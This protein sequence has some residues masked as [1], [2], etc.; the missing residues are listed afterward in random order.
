MDSTTKWFHEEPIATAR[1]FL[2]QLHPDNDR[3]GLGQKCDWIFRGVDDAKHLLLPKAWRDA[4]APTLRKSVSVKSEKFLSAQRMSARC[5]GQGD[6][7]RI[8]TAVRQHVAELRAVEQFAALAD[9]VGR[10]AGTVDAIDANSI[11]SGLLGNG[12]I[13]FQPTA[14]LAVAQHHGVPT[15]LLDWTDSP[16]HAAVFASDTWEESIGKQ[17]CVY[18][19]ASSGPHI[20]SRDVPFEL[21]MLAPQIFRPVRSATQ[22]MVAQ[23]GCFTF[24]RNP[25]GFYVQHG[26]WPTV[27]DS[28]RE[29]LADADTPRKGWK[30]C[31]LVKLTLPG[32]EVPDLVRRLLRHNLTRAHLMPSLDSVGFAV[33]RLWKIGARYG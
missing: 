26:R 2:A 31:K 5:P 14:L 30:G 11:Q 12:Y 15:R 21:R 4:E 25:E 20:L 6:Y 8:K 1:D 27:E 32:E 22:H 28:I 23:Q 33:R 13:T 9:N 7:G 19:L 17:I 3:W 10:G 16:L 29:R 18:A 24:V